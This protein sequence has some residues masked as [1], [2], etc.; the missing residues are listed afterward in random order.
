MA[1]RLEGLLDRLLDAEPD[2]REAI[3]SAQARSEPALADRARALLGYAASS[4]GIADNVERAAPGLIRAWIESEEPDRVGQRI[5]AYEIVERIGQGGMGVVYRAERADGLFEQTVA[6]KFVGAARQSATAHALFDRERSHLARLEHPNIARMIDAGLSADGAPYFIMEHVTGEPLDAHARRVRGRARLALVGQ[7]CDAVAYC[8]RN[9]IIHG[10]IKPG[11]VLVSDGRARLLDFG[12][13]HL[14]DAS[15]SS[16]SKAKGW[17]PEF[18]APELRAEGVASVQSDIYALGIVIERVLC[19]RPS[20]HALSA[21]LKAIVAKAT[22][23][24]PEHRYDTVAALQ[25]DLAAYRDKR[26]VAAR[27]GGRLYHAWKFVD[28][29]RGLVGATILLMTSLAAGLVASLW[30][31]REARQHAERA[32]AVAGFV[33]G[34]FERAHPDRAGERDVTLLEMLN[35]AD[36]R[37]SSEL[38]DAPRVR[39]DLMR[40]VALGYAGVGES[41]RAFALNRGVLDYWKSQV[42]PPH[43]EL[44]RSHNRVGAGLRAHGRYDEAIAAHREAMRQLSAL[45]LERSQEA[46]STWEHLGRALMHF[47]STEAVFAMRRANEIFERLAPSDDGQRARSLA[48]VAA[49]LRV[50]GQD[51]EAIRYSEDALR[52]AERSDQRMAPSI[53]ATRCNLALDYMSLGRFD[54]ARR[55]M[56]LCIDQNAQRLGSDHPEL[57]SSYNNLGA[58]ELDVGRVAAAL[59]ALKRSVALARDALPER[60]LPR[61]AAEI[62]YA[63]ALW[64]SGEAAAASETLEGVL[65]RVRESFGDDHPATARVRSILGR[66]RLDEEGVAGAEEM[67][68]RSV[69]RLSGKWR[70]DALLWLAE[71][72]LAAGRPAEAARLADECA[73]LRRAK[74]FAAGWT[75]AEA[76]FIE[77]EASGDAAARAAASA[78]LARLPEPHIRRRAAASRP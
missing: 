24:E 77:A 37:L 78:V 17:S 70:A 20:D 38:A 1:D 25:A 9:L 8:H 41:E 23:A 43:L 11:N 2:E 28:R 66:T 14:I 13:G 53:V 46:A 7:V 18:A 58:L 49:A 34:L 27:D 48:N 68:A 29:E 47:D 69:E 57:V 52:I 59:D 3:L 50:D 55:T 12:V 56:R 15:G 36:Q 19:A 40:L 75:I 54:A 32:Q 72:K 44:A 64:L 76:E 65:P 74:P 73:K 6:V 30:Q 10:D 61:M 71:A 4:P 35:E 26:P 62:N 42:D 39:A 21:D 22:A 60:A 51:E 45:G 16:G 5:G 31:Y 33:T 67:L 63:R